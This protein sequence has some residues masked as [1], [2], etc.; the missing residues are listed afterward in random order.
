VLLQS[1]IVKLVYT[2]PTGKETL[3]GL[4]S[5]G[6]WINPWLVLARVPSL[7][8]VQAVTRCAV[9]TVP[10]AQFQEHLRGNPALM[11]RILA[12]QSHE[13]MILSQRVLDLSARPDDRMRMPAN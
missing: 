12:A 6:W 11:L 9:A 1:G 13:V 7:W 4:R 3:L 10:A 5:Q 2:A 8:S